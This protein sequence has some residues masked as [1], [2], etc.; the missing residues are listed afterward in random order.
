M[1]IHAKKS[2]LMI[3]VGLAMLVG[4]YLGVFAGNLEPPGPPA[5]TMKTLDEV[6]PRIPIHAAD[7]PLTITQRGS[8]YLVEDINTAGGG[9]QVSK[10]TDDVTIDLEGFT[11]SG[12]TGVGIRIW[13]SGEVRNGRVKGWTGD[14]MNLGSGSRV[15]DVIAEGCGGGGIVIGQSGLVF[16]STAINNTGNGISTACHSMVLNS[17]ATSNLSN[18]I[19]VACYSYISGNTFSSNAAAGIS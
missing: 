17:N 5:P 18:G 4:V 10:A 19:L 11:L 3:V 15:V 9:I 1:L 7:L 14:C 12:G 13:L 2:T 8:Y 6:E 16:D